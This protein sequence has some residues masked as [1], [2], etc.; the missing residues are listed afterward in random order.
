VFDIQ[1]VSQI[2]IRPA[3]SHYFA[4]LNVFIR[5]KLFFGAITPINFFNERWSFATVL[6]VKV[7]GVYVDGYFSWDTTQTSTRNF[8]AMLND[9]CSSWPTSD[10][11]SPFNFMPVFD[12][13]FSGFPQGAREIGYDNRSYS[14]NYLPNIAAQKSKAISKPALSAD[15]EA[16]E[17][18]GDQVI[19]LLII[20]GV[21]LIICARPKV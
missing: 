16:T 18:V 19:V 11:I 5:R 14:S 7:D 2:F 15:S 9:L 10:N 6:N 20:I 1:P 12:S 8:D 4:N 13:V 21:S 17:D 3:I